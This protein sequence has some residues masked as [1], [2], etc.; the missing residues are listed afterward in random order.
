MKSYTVN[1]NAKIVSSA[2]G[3]RRTYT[4]GRDDEFDVYIE[5]LKNGS[6]VLSLS[7]GNTTVVL[8]PHKVNTL[9]R[10]L[11]KHFS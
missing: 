3:S 8:T 5:Q 11:D 10:V 6:N 9:K 2:N 4:S 1:K 7:T